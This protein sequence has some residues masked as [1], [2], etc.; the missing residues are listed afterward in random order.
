MYYPE[1][2]I[3]VAEY[4]DK[5]ELAVVTAVCKSWNEAL[6]PCLYSEVGWTTTNKR[7]GRE[8]LQK[9]AHHV[10]SLIISLK[11][12]SEIPMEKFTRLKRLHIDTTGVDLETWE[13]FASLLYRNKMLKELAINSPEAVIPSYI[14]VTISRCL[15][16]R[17]LKLVNCILDQAC[18]TRLLDACAQL[19]LE[20]LCLYS[21]SLTQPPSLNRWEFKSIRDLFILGQYYQTFGQELQWVQRCPSL[22][23]LSWNRLEYETATIP[24]FCDTLMNRCKNIEELTLLRW[25]LPDE[26]IAKVIN[27]TR[28]LKK[29]NIASSGFGPI[30]LKA[31]NRFSST[32]RCF[33][34]RGC[35]DF[36][37]A[38]AQ[39]VLTSFP[40][41][42]EF[43]GT[44]MSVQ[45][46]LGISEGKPGAPETTT[47]PESK[48]PPRDWTCK[49]LRNFLVLL[50]GFDKN[51]PEWQRQVLQ[52]IAK[53]EKL[54]H[55]SVGGNFAELGEKSAGLE[56]R[57][58]AGLD[59][60][61]SLK[62]M[63]I[64]HFAGLHPDMDEQDVRWMLSS[65]PMLSKVKGQLH[66]D[67]VQNKKLADILNFKSKKLYSLG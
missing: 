12:H 17:K 45:D 20:L 39:Q 61:G 50:Y 16:M 52:K 24:E 27:S 30:S 11:L 66:S 57:L 56:V 18:T 28:N 15:S 2:R 22:R 42:E 33:D 3:Q 31:C 46:I 13:E 49:N 29:F 5:S 34:A 55:L 37:G 10:R 40:H 8:T 36:T 26:E 4:L 1:L 53:L 59:I 38:M 32:L 43:I 6:T 62:Q 54:E 48:D 67:E 47:T 58:N 14:F 19:E 51:H 60:L 9:H 7:I 41:L 44:T 25:T 23:A 21:T 65:W 63:N 35:K 64:F